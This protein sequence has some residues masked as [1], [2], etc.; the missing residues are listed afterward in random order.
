MRIAPKAEVTILDSNVAEIEVGVDV[1]DPLISYVVNNIVQVNAPTHRKYKAIQA[2]TGVDPV[3]DV[4]PITGIGT[5]WYDNG[6]TNYKRAFDELGSSKCENIDSIYYKFATSDIDVLMLG[7]LTGITV[8]IVLTNVDTSTVMLDETYDT[9]SREVYDWQEW[10][11]EPLEY[12][13]SF[14]K[15]LPFIY[16]ATMEVW[17][18]NTGFTASAGHIVFGRSKNYGLSLIDPKPISSRRGINSKTRDEYG[19]I[20]T[21]RKARYR[22]MKIT[23]IIDSSSIDII[24]DRLELIVDTPCIFVGDEQDGGIKALLVYGEMKDHDMPISRTKTTYQL[25]VEGYQ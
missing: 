1:F 4:N 17:I 5:Y 19:N 20:I 2:S 11:V 7:G 12:H 21:R 3:L 16:N 9:Q 18:D 25:E 8:R 15:I 22:R 23:C 6:A 10:I 24:E 13:S 14:F